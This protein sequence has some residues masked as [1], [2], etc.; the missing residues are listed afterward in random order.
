MTVFAGLVTLVV[1]AF[2]ARL[3]G[4]ALRPRASWWF[5]TANVLVFVAAVGLVL[6]STL[7]ANDVLWGIGLGLGCGGL[8][9]LRYGW[10]GL[11]SVG[12]QGRP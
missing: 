1:A 8:A 3:V 7:T 5:W 10:K 2:A 9:G 6:A 11:F 12:P 4:R